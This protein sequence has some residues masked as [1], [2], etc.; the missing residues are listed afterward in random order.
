[1]VSLFWGNKDNFEP[2]AFC[3]KD[4]VE[5]RIMEFLDEQGYNEDIFYIRSWTER[6]VTHYDYVDL[7]HF[8]YTVPFKI[9]MED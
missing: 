2:V 8:F 9:N 3:P 7:S 4:E 6:G 5:A 1:M